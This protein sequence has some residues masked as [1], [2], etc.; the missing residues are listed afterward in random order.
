MVKQEEAEGNSQTV[1]R[2]FR[3]HTEYLSIYGCRWNFVLTYH[4]NI[5]YVSCLLNK[6]V[7]ST[8]VHN[9]GGPIINY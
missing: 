7:Y 8:P 3:I 4:T 6:Y 2:G 9:R 1:G 5:A